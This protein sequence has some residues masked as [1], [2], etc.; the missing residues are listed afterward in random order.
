[1]ATNEQILLDQI[2]DQE[3]E[4][5]AKE[6][7][8]DDFFLIFAV[9]QVIK[10]FDLSYDEIQ[11]GIVD[12]SDDGGL[13][14]IY[15]FINGD[16]ILEPIVREAYKKYPR[17]DFFIIQAKNSATF[18]EVPVERAVVNISRLF[19]LDKEI[20]EFEADFNSEL[21]QQV[22]LFRDTYLELAALQPTLLVTFSYITQGRERKC[23]QKNPEYDEPLRKHHLRL[24]P[25]C[26]S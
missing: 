20:S 9:E 3:R 19:A 15:T 8:Q 11:N 2:L 17:V 10:K 25:W 23:A 21:I 13:D 12:G 1:M 14:A 5:K 18:R 16:L 7:D 24:L 6:L 4:A 22:S 26:S